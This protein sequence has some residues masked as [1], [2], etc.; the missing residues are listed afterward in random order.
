MPTK[1]ADLDITTMDELD[2]VINKAKDT[3]DLVHVPYEITKDMIR[4]AVLTLEDYNKK[5]A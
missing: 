1:L 4:E 2:I 3:Q 5:M